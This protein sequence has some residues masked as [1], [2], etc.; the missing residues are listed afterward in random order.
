MSLLILEHTL[1]G[2]SEYT[3]SCSEFRRVLR[4]ER[5]IGW[6]GLCCRGQTRNHGIA[7][8]EML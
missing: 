7:R 4:E 8:A 3:L 6:G 5:G 1:S 2:F